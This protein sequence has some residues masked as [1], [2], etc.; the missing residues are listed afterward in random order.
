MDLMHPSLAYLFRY[1]L[2]CHF[3]DDLPTGRFLEIGVG[4]GCFYR[5][6][7]K[8]GFEGTCL[9]LNPAVILMHNRLKFPDYAGIR[10]ENSNFSSVAESFDLLIAFEVLE[11]YLDDVALL[12][13]WCAKL[14]P[15]GRMILSVP[16]HMR[17]WTINDSLA[18]HVRRYE[19]EELRDRLHQAGLEVEF[20]WSYGCPLLNWTYRFSGSWKKKMQNR[21]DEEGF[22]PKTS[23]SEKEENPNLFS[24]KKTA[25][26][27]NYSFG[28]IAEW[29]FQ[30]WIWWPFLLWQKSCLKDDRGIGYLV[31]CRIR[32][33]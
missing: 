17:K 19:K 25:Q 15:G 26:S 8:R 16:A 2:A 21:A 3:L 12:K 30:Q 23:Q 1:D 7:R 27:G 5:E 20:L 24:L 32:N 13:E 9:D 18:G 33:G 14:N 31:R 10:F 4:R 22:D 28:K 11:H 6:L 29:F